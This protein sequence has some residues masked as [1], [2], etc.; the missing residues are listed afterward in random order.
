[1][2][3]PYIPA[4]LQWPRARGCSPYLLVIHTMEAAESSK[5]AES[6]ARFFQNA[7]STG[8][9]HLC[10]DNDSIVQSVPFDHKA[11]GAR[12]FPYRTKSVNDWAV[13]FEHAG[14]ARQTPAEWADDFS[15]KML[16]W[17]A[18]AAAR[19]CKAYSIPVVSVDEAGLRA[20]A[21]GIT[22]HRTVSQAFH[23]PGGHTDPGPAFPMATYLSGVAWGL[24]KL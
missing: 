17:S 23:V 2:D 7:N 11:A 6:C 9:A 12:G 1:M 3:Y 20:G 22:T 24:S 21:K 14:Y 4:R 16:F 10:I 19:V 5:T 13:H 18:M 15:Q 8:S